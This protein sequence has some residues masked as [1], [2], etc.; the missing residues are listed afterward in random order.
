[1]R[2][3]A[4]SP[5]KAWAAAPDGL[6]PAEPGGVNAPAST[7]LA[8]VMVVCGSAIDARLAHEAAA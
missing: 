6:A 3:N 8:S 5:R 7:T 1:M 4:G 2:Q